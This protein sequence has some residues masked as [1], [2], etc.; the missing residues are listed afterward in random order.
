M[1]YLDPIG[2]FHKL[3][4][5]IKL[6]PLYP[7]LTLTRH[8]TPDDVTVDDCQEIKVLGPNSAD[9]V[10]VKYY[11]VSI[12][13]CYSREGKL[14]CHYKELSFSSDGIE[15]YNGDRLV[16]VTRSKTSTCSNQ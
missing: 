10:E 6:E 11:A 7:E 1:V 12:G 4:L 16:R 3:S 8:D 5:P 15:I 14:I 9:P 2:T 13:H